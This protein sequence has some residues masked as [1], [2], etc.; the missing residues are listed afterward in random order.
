LEGNSSARKNP[1]LTSGFLFDD[2]SGPVF[3]LLIDAPD[4]FGDD[5]E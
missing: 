2:I 4:I 5:A 1:D 3:D